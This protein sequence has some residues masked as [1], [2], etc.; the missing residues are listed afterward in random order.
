MSGS[1]RRSERLRDQGRTRRYEN[2][3]TRGEDEFD[4]EEY[5]KRTFDQVNHLSSSDSDSFQS[6]GS[7]SDTQSDDSN[8]T[9]I[10]DQQGLAE[11][12]YLLENNL[13]ISVNPDRMDALAA[14]R[15][16]RKLL[17][18][19]QA[20]VHDINDHL[21]ENPTGSISDIDD[22]NRNVSKIEKLRTD[23]RE[24]HQEVADYMLELS[25]GSEEIKTKLDEFNSEKKTL[26][27]EVKKYVSSCNQVR[28]AIRGNESLAR[29]NMSL[30]ENR[31]SQEEFEQKSRTT[32]F[33]LDE[34][35]R[36]ITE[37]SSEFSKSKNAD[38][39]SDEELSR[40]NRELTDY[41]AR[42]EKISKKQ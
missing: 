2:Y 13:S 39:V 25:E 28:T 26:L 21:D 15:E 14:D 42:M 22:I 5:G 30:E 18:K 17:R 31:R 27:G 32:N 4:Y 6:V 33:I 23:F 41:L 20:I 10:E 29:Q 24:A 16:Y 12:T 35:K 8:T 37:L 34:I 1:E 36:M 19:V 11:L 3:H 9:V 38:E 7:G 40:R